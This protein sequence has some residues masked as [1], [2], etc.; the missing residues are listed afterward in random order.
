LTFTA[1]SRKDHLNYKN[2]SS[3]D[4]I[5]YQTDNS[6]PHNPNPDKLTVNPLM[7]AAYDDGMTAL[8]PSQFVLEY[9]PVRN[10]LLLLHHY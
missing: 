2:S 3:P 5:Q 10:E 4:Q 8:F 7:K 1:W 6:F 9:L